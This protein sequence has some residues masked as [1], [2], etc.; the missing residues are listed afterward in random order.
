MRIYGLLELVG[1]DPVSI[2]RETIL[3]QVG[4]PNR[5]EART[6]D[7]RVCR[8]LLPEAR[9][10]DR[11]RSRGPRPGLGDDLRQDSMA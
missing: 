1:R 4:R 9:V 7:C 8:S 11:G 10:R 2:R 6:T 3:F 5:R